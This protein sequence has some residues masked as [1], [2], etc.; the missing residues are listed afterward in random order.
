MIQWTESAQQAFAAYS[1]RIRQTFANSDVDAE[2]VIDDVRRHIETDA[3]ASQLSTI[4]E[5]DVQRILA[6][7]G[8]F[9]TPEKSSTPPASASAPKTLIPESTARKPGFFLLLFGVILPLIT[10]TFEFFTGA[11]AGVLFDPFSTW[12]NTLAILLV[13]AING[14]MW[15]AGRAE[16]RRFLKTTSWLSGAA[17]GVC[18]FYTLLYLPFTPFAFI[19]I[20]WFGMGLLPLAPLL[21]LLATPNMRYAYRSR[22]GLPLL[23][24]FR[25]GIGAMLLALVLA[26]TPNAVTTYGLSRAISEDTTTSLRGIR[27]LRAVGNEELMLRAC[28][29]LLQRPHNLDVIRFLFADDKRIHSEP[30]R[31]IYYRVTGRAF[32]SVPPPTLYTRAGR[33]D[34]MDEEFFWDEALGGESVSARVKGLTLQNSR[35]DIAVEP[36]A[37]TAYYEWTMEFKNVATMARE[38]RAQLALPPGG[39]VSRLTLWV[40]GEEREAAFAGRAQVRAAYQSVAV[41]QRRDPV[42]VT[43][44]G[45]DRVLMQC[46]PVPA[47]GGTMKIRVGITAPLQLSSLA[48]GEFTWPKFLERN[49]AYAADLKHNLWAESPALITTEGLGLKKGEPKAGY[50]T[51][52]G[53]LTDELF[54]SPTAPILV[55]RHADVRE[56]WTPALES[57]QFIHQQIQE[58]PTSI[59]SRLII[60]VDGS[61]NMKP[62]V[63]EIAEALAHLPDGLEVMAYLASDVPKLLLGEPQK[64]SATVRAELQRALR[65]QSFN[66]GQDNLPALT[67]AWDTALDS[68]QSAVL[69]IHGSQPVIVSSAEGLRQQMQRGSKKTRFFDFQTHSGPNRLVESL[70][71]LPQVNLAPRHATVTKDL[72]NLFAQWKAGAARWE[73]IRHQGSGTA[74]GLQVSRHIERLWAR[75]EAAKLA[76][77]GKLAAAAALAAKNQLVTPLT[78]AVVL[79]TQA[80]FDA[81]GLTPVDASSVPSIPEPATWALLMAGLLLVCLRRKM[82]LH[83]A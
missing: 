10:I 59:P 77:E 22:L 63:T 46:F 65:S 43:T 17:V 24:G 45:P 44:C 16:D 80:Q 55:Q 67:T 38:A 41:V 54:L 71:G 3:Q 14:W 70:D 60:V 6:R 32:N 2:E 31:N 42:L 27:V 64:V 37:A 79:E 73:P 26:E 82:R 48:Q 25:G 34:A 19:G 57:G 33:W 51:L 56:V 52:R 21:A 12:F 78:G 40:N 11:S 49:F 53:A 4:T 9:S 1:Q 8:D 76:R 61:A 29:G 68:P 50:H 18:L 81:H 5:Q 83:Q 35:I 62:H 7:F 75:D 58:T 66:G 15:W 30:A 69:W 13:P 20:I 28:Y 36:D 74:T 23:P 39:V 72:A 47:N